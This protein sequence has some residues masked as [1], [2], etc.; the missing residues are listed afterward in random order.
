MPR[1]ERAECCLDRI[2]DGSMPQGGSCSGTVAN[3]AANA[4]A[5]ITEDE[6]ALIEAWVNA[7]IPETAGDEGSTNDPNAAGGNAAGA[8]SSGDDGGGCQATSRTHSWLAGLMADC[9]A[10]LAG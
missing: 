10:N 1:Q 3:D 5:C 9:L 4:D 2:A 8:T 7:G 6:F